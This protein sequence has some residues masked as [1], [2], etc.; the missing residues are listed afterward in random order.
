MK[1]VHIANFYGST[2][3]GI[4]TTIHELGG[5]Y[6]RYGIEFIYIVPGPKF[7]KEETKFGTRISLP[8]K[9]IPFTGG[10]QII[11]SNK[12]L[13]T[14][15]EYLKPDRLEVSDRF[16]LFKV[17]KWAKRMKI[18]AIV[19]SHETLAGLT[20]RFLPFVPNKIRNLF[21]NSQN[22]RLARVFDQVVVTTDFAGG[23]FKRIGISNLRKVSLGVDL[24]GFT[25]DHFDR[26]LKREL[27]D[28]HD[29]LLMYC[30]RLSPEKE[31]Q[32]VLEALVQL[33]N[34]GI[35]AKLVVLGGGAL[36]R[37]FRNQAIGLPVNM[38]GYVASRE[39]IAQH[40]SC[41]DVVMAPGPLETFCLS[42]LEALASGVPVVASASSAV[43]EI[44]GID[45]EDQAGL[46]AENNGADFASTVEEILFN[47][48]FK[49][50]A[51]ARAERYSWR[52]TIDQ[53]LIAHDAKP[54]MVTTKR[55]LRVA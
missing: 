47:S 55:R 3:G 48:K 6:Q 18:P 19:F 31:P 29:F 52:N 42:A 2:S 39:K 40:L 23:E 37:K 21:V 24:Q 32:R 28:S 25:P 44:L 38:I 36:W 14:L 34:R 22:R 51:R 20:K 5:G 17:G 43:G 16:T 26:R 49:Q 41:A 10:Y 9:T 53:M 4:K 15:L 35:N 46:V 12:Q 13:I 1:I 27:K 8:S 54:K 45:Q 7:S 30:G 50:N 11:K 33:R